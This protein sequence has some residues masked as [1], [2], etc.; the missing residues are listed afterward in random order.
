MIRF[1]LCCRACHRRSSSWFDVLISLTLVT[2][3]TT[4]PVKTRSNQVLWYINI[5]GYIDF[6]IY[7]LMTWSNGLKWNIKIIDQGMEDSNHYEILY[8]TNNSKFVEYCQPAGINIYHRF[9]PEGDWALRI[10]QGRAVQNRH[11]HKFKLGNVLLV[12]EDER[13]CK[14]EF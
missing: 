7:L 4:E 3:N 1:D 6:I 9:I 5:F 14:Y 2:L 11:H 10:S 8:R 13:P 12:V